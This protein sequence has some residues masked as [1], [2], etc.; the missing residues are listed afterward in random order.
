MKHILE[1]DQFCFVCGEKNPDGLHL[2]F[3]LSDGQV[4]AEFIPRKIHQ[5]YK[6]I[7]HGGLL[8][9]IL[10]EAMVKAAL[11]QGVPVVTAELTVR[12]KNPL[13]TGEKATVEAAIIKSNRKIIEA[14]AVIKKDGAVIAEG[15][16]K[17]IRRD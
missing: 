4:S 9:T 1:D 15:T 10:D 12:F 13:R 8:S 11:M 3:V 16:A 17:L 2:A 6:D 7:T 14:T 5:G